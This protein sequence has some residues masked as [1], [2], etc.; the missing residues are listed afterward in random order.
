MKEPIK[1]MGILLFCD[2][3]DNPMRKQLQKRGNTSSLQW[4]KCYDRGKT[5][6]I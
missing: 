3:P 2:S 1:R 4:E 5:E 6:N